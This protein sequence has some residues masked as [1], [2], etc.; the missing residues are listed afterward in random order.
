MSWHR[1]ERFC[2]KPRRKKHIDTSLAHQDWVSLTSLPCILPQASARL[3]LTPQ[4]TQE[5]AKVNS[6]N[7]EK[8][9]ADT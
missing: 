7:I 4:P 2:E 5:D 1:Q 8:F 6:D 9:H 3:T